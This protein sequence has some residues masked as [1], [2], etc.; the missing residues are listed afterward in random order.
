LTNTME[1][2]ATPTH[3]P[4]SRFSENVINA[5]IEGF[6]AQKRRIDGQ[7]AELKALLPGQG[8][9]V[10]ATSEPP[11]HKISTAARRRMALGQKR[12]WAAIKGAAEPPA[13]AVTPEPAKAKRK[14]SAAGRKAIQEA[15]RR[16]WA[17]KRAEAA[18]AQRAT[19]KAARKKAGVKRAAV[20][21]TP[22]KAAKR[23]RPV[24]KTAVKKVAIKKKAPASTQPPTE[25]AT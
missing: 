9:E 19:K 10:A 12:R 5:A 20:R 24:K 1:N 25:T 16:R 14:L 2:R 13:P 18:K 15:L 6:E 22:A 23:S 8:T 4:K 7:I 17:Q 3:M 21:A 11:K